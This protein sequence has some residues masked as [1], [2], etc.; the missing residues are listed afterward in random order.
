MAKIPP[1]FNKELVWIEP[2]NEV[3]KNLCGWLGR[4][5]IHIANLAQR[6]GYKV[7]LFAW[8]SGEPEAEGWLKPEMLD[9]L[10]L[11]AKRPEQ[12]AVAIHEYSFLAHN[13]NDGRPYKVGR[14]QLLFDIC[15]RHNISRPTIHITEWG[16]ALDEVPSSQKAIEH[17]IDIG[18][19]YAPYPTIKGAAIW[20]LGPG[21]RGVAN[22]T[23]RLIK[24]MADFTLRHTF[25][26]NASDE[27]APVHLPD[28]WPGYDPDAPVIGEPP[29]VP[30]PVE[31]IE[32][33]EPEEPEIPDPVEPI[34]PDPIEPT[35]P[36]E[37]EIPDPVEPT[38]PQP[39]GIYIA[40]VTIPDDTE[41]EA[42]ATFTKT[43]RVKNTGN[44]AWGEWMQLVHVGGVVMSE[45]VKRPLFAVAP[46]EEA[47]I[48]LPMIAPTTP[49][50]H[51]TDYRFQDEHGNPFGEIIYARI[52]VKP[53]ADDNDAVSNALYV[54]DVT[55]PDDTVMVAG[56]KFVKTWRIRNAGTRPWDNNFSF[57][58]VQGVAMTNVTR[59]SAPTLAPG[60]EGEISL[61]LTAPSKKGTHFGDWQMRDDQGN[62]FGEFIFLRIVV[63]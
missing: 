10:R 6:D 12:A 53:A 43:W 3:D 60:E 5:A 41:F 7:S 16:W 48:S 2:I 21:F 32:P 34:E 31:P 59:Q 42:G 13:I 29:D 30:D 14:F 54:A 44:V 38:E 8:S 35:E 23:Q 15:D 20:Y 27:P 56:E 24:P 36:E 49:G 33:T 62:L 26:V 40:D 28:D 1:E 19:L 4:F 47:E 39:N 51:F 22:Q 17:V 61:S 25:N 50:I 46:N 9:Y 55:I 45:V 11:C 58:F 57:D 52:V 63:R 37:P 18:Q